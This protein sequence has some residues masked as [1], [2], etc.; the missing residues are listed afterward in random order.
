MRWKASKTL[1]CFCLSY[2]IVFVSSTWK[3]LCCFCVQCLELRITLA[4]ILFAAFV[5]R[6][7]AA[8]NGV[9]VTLRGLYFGPSQGNTAGGSAAPGRWPCRLSRTSLRQRRPLN[10]RHFTH[11]C[12]ISRRTTHCLGARKTLPGWAWEWN[13][14]SRL[15]YIYGLHINKFYFQN[16]NSGYACEL[17]QQG[18]C[19]HLEMGSFD[20][21]FSSSGFYVRTQVGPIM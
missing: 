4:V 7:L 9:T 3:N 18:K 19:T 20:C 8:V 5:L 1:N 17:K 14:R 10:Y 16:H 15:I 2:V 12:L 11:T 13:S 21:R 6:R